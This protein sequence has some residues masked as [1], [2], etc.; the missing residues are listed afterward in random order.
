M[1]P[2]K[3]IMFYVGVIVICLFS[4]FPFIWMISTSLKAPSEVYNYPPTLVPNTFSLD[5][6][7]SILT[8]ST[9]SFNFRLWIWNSIKVASLTTLFSMMVASLGGYAMSRYKFIGRTMLGYLIIIVQVLPG[10]LLIIPIYTILSRLKM[11]NSLIGLVCACL[12]VSVPFCTWSMKGYF[13][14]IP[15]SID[16]AA[17]IDGCNKFTAFFRVVLP[18]TLPGLV[19]TAIFSF[20]TGW[21][22]FLYA[23]VLLKDYEKWT[24]P[25]GLTTFKGQYATNWNGIMAGGVLVTIPVV[26]IFWVLQKYLISGMTAGA[27]KQ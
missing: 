14:T 15:I 17:C 12:T 21:N 8:A 4:A 23:S 22:E 5:G 10:S 27:V 19:S 9:S 3:T 6:Y 2:A 24:I 18:L 25:V 20:I 7:R 13:D 11:L 26:I 1:K 16:E